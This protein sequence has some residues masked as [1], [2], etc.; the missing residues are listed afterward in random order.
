MKDTTLNPSSDTFSA[1]PPAPPSSVFNL[2]K[3]ILAELYECD[4]NILNNTT[5]I[6]QFMIEAAE[7]CGATVVEKNF[8]RFSPFGVSGVVIIAESHLAIH[9]WPEFGYAAVDL[10]TCGDSCKPDVAYEYLKEKFNAGSAF[11]SELTRGMMNVQTQE[12]IHA[13]FQVRHEKDERVMVASTQPLEEA[14][15]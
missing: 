6:E 7:V 13:P 1:E 15:Q 12:L 4:S 9:T 3:H 10:F 8:H 14:L 2:G 11:C 5:L